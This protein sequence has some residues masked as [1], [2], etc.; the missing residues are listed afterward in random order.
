MKDGM[1]KDDAQDSR[2]EMSDDEL[3]AI[4]RAEE[5]DA[6]SYYTS[7]LAT[8]QA[9]AMD[10]YFAAPYGNEIENRSQVRTH[11]IEDTIN[12][13]LPDL[14]R[15]F[16]AG[17]MVSCTPNAADDEDNVDDAADYLEHVFFV[18][19]P[20]AA[21][22]HDFA[23]D[24]LLQRLGVISVMWEDPKPRIP[25]ILEGVTVEQ[26]MKL[27]AD[28]EYEILEQ[29]QKDAPAAAQPAPPPDPM[30]PMPPMAA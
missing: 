16:K 14:M 8:D 15:V 9:D 27:D 30:T 12:W 7:E 25:Q 5:T 26:L 18:D 13:I 20:G 21:I 3:I 11:D 10:R 28:P 23:F 1:D 17:E 6:T 22:I 24:G 4:L 19:N 29:E 2:E